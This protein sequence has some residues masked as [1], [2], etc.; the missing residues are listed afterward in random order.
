MKQKILSFKHRDNIYHVLPDGRFKTSLQSKFQ[1]E[2]YFLGGSPK[3]SD[4]TVVVSLAQ[5]FEQ[6]TLLNNC[7][8]WVNVNERVVLYVSYYIGRIAVIRECKLQTIRC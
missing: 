8:M 2:R 5:A 7:I 4:K 1:A 3:E 6:P